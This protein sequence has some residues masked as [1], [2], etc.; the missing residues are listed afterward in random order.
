MTPKITLEQLE[1]RIHD[2]SLD[3]DPG[4]MRRAGYRV[5]DWM[6]QRLAHLRESSLG[7]ELSRE[8]TEKLLR[9]ALPEEPSNFDQVFDEYTRKVAPNVIQLDHPRFFAFVPSAPNFVSV[10]ADALVAGTNVFAGTW[11]ESSGPP[12]RIDRHRLVQADAGIASGSCGVAGEWWVG[13]QPDGLGRGA[14][15]RPER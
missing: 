8:E 12:G 13:C 11:L 9:E 7:Q 4:S 2:V 6:V 14:A 3:L 5:V 1:A 10:L 15:R